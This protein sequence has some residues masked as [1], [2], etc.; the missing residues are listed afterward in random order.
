MPAQWLKLLEYLAART[1]GV[2]PYFQ[3]AVDELN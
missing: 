3:H 2:V 1:V